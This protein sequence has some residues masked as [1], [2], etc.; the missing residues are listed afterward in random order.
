MNRRHRFFLVVFIALGL[1]S[2]FIASSFSYTFSLSSA[3]VLNSDSESVTFQEY[4]WLQNP[5]VLLIHICL[6]L[7]GAFGVSALLPAKEEEVEQ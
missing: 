4:L 7:A 5:L 3:D 1:V 6:I 2:V